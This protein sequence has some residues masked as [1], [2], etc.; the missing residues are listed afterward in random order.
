M[1]CARNKSGLEG[2]F[3]KITRARE[4][5]HELDRELDEWMR[6]TQHVT[7]R[8]HIT[9]AGAAGILRVVV[10]HVDSL[11]LRVSVIL[12]ELIH[13][14]RSALDNVAWELA[15]RNRGHGAVSR[16]TSF[17][18][19][20]NET[21]FDAARTQARL[22]HIA[23]EHVSVIRDCQPFDNAQPLAQLA[24][25]SNTDKHRTINFLSMSGE[26]YREEVH[27]VRDCSLTDNRS[28]YPVTH[29]LE[30]APSRE[31]AVVPLA[32]SGPSPLA[33][34]FVRGRIRVVVETGDDVLGLIGDIGR[35]TDDIL[36]RFDYLLSK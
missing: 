6:S 29:A 12:G 7:L 36:S 8:A 3:A 27:T 14:L 25:L 20:T 15:V 17:P 32:I 11:P 28:E 9:G 21:E 10:D 34:A 23:P 13:D 2:A 5:S 26:D 18:I 30:L 16:R 1:A 35:A 33:E 31:L 19:C 22:E 4:L 24:R